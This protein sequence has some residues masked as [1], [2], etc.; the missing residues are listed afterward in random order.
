[1]SLGS[2]ILSERILPADSGQTL[3]DP[4]VLANGWKIYPLVDSSV[5]ST[6]L[7]AYLEVYNVPVDSSTRVPLIRLK[8]CIKAAAIEPIC[9]DLTNTSMTVKGDRATLM[10]IFAIGALKAGSYELAVE[11]HNLSSGEVLSQSHSFEK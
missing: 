1:M 11:V 2:L 3:A 5:S 8:S 4:F 9:E 7:V 10:K 6:S